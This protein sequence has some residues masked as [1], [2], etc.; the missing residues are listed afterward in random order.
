MMLESVPSITLKKNVSNSYPP[1]FKIVSKLSQIMKRVRFSENNTIIY[2]SVNISKDLHE[3]RKSNF[4][5]RMADKF[6]LE[7]ILTPILCKQHRNRIYSAIYSDA[8]SCN[9]TVK[10][11]TLE[12][13]P[14]T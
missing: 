2:E 13:E 14:T 7:K 3:S 1:I 11:L 12:Y 5:Q 6:R 9:Q 10:E 4:S 8:V